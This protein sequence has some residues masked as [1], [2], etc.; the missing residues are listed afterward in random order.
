MNEEKTLKDEIRDLKNIISEDKQTK[1]KKWKLPYKAKVGNAKLKKGYVT[2]E[3]IN[4]NKAIDFVREQII[5]GTIKIGDTYH[6]VDDLDLFF[7]KGK[8]FVHQPKGSIYS[9]NP[10]V[11]QKT[12][13]QSNT[14]YGQKYVMARMEGDKILA[15][16]AGFGWGIGI[17]LLVI[18]GIVV[19]YL[20]TGK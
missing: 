16:K 8:P 14:T 4:E 13:L 15:K 12:D 6:A 17:G 1:Q 5:D 7:Y 19:Y 10:L 9:Y 2:V 11:R 3:I 20:L 18:V